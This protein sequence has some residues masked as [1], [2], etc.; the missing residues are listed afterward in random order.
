[1]GQ[2]HSLGLTGRHNFRVGRVRFNW[3]GECG[4]KGK[5]GKHCY[6]I[7]A[8]HKGKLP[9]TVVA[10]S[11]WEV[12]LMWSGHGDGTPLWLASAGYQRSESK[13]EMLRLVPRQFLAG[14]R[15]RSP[16]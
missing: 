11:L 2:H 8:D 9:R 6:E 1:L 13:R 15:E 5:P 7:Y 4:E 3:R 16:K 14:T 10:F 12:L